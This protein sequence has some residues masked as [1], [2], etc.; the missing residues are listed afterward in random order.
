M[1]QIRRRSAL[2]GQLCTPLVD[3]PRPSKYTKEEL[4][5]SLV[6]FRCL[7]FV[8]PL[9]FAVSLLAV[10]ELWLASR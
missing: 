7:Y 5:A 8:L 3:R 9:M 6:I 1:A 2:A 10:R 4:L